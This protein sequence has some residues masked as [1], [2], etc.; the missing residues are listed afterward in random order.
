MN[1]KRAFFI[2]GIILIFS[3][4]LLAQDIEEKT[5]YLKSGGKITGK[6]I[7]TDPETGD[8]EIQTAYGVLEIKGEDILQEVVSIILKS[9]DVLKG[10]IIY[11]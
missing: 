6:I 9:G 8:I 5:I 10:L 11:E 1:C 3:L 4:L 2:V 7:S